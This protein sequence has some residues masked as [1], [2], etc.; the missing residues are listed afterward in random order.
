MK[1]MFADF[2]AKTSYS[3][4]S[5]PP[6]QEGH[7]QPALELPW[8][9]DAELVTLPDPKDL[10][11]P[12]ADLRQII[13]Q[14]RSL[15]RYDHKPLTL[16][17]LSYLLWLTQGIKRITG[18][19]ATLRT[20]PSA[21]ARH[22]FETYLLINRVDGV[23][24]GLYRYIATRHALLRVDAPANVDVLMTVACRQQDHVLQSAV[25]FVWMAVAERMAWRYVERSLRYLYL[26]AGHVC[27]NLYLAA[28]AIDC[29]VCAIAAFDDEPLNQLIG[30]DGADCFAIYMATVGKK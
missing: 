30:A 9:A 1:A 2:L 27:Q 18:R 25:T 26:D 6:Q 28:E 8:P 13:E 3:K 22:A 21:G 4:L 5:P 16:A 19:P 11:F 20:V 14:R 24:A 12:S 23:M 17:E 29:G 15:R 7:P 10:D